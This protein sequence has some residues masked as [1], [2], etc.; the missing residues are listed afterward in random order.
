VRAVPRPQRELVLI[1]DARR[2]SS[3]VVSRG[4]WRLLG[5]ERLALAILEKPRAV[6]AAVA[7]AT[8]VRQ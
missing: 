7:T 1:R 6:A 2:R 5:R 4:P 3:L 8:A